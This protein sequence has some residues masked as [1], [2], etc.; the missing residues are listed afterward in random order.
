MSWRYSNRLSTEGSRDTVTDAWKGASAKV[1][2][3]VRVLFKQAVTTPAEIVVRAEKELGS[4]AASM[5]VSAILSQH[6][7][8]EGKDMLQCS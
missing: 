1:V 8:G 4:L 7:E 3:I 5:L 6:E 2:E